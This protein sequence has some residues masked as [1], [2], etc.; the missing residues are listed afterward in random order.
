MV[1]KQF[2][3]EVGLH[4]G[5]P[6]VPFVFI[7]PVDVFSEEQQT[8]DLIELLFADDFVLVSKIEEDLLNKTLMWQKCYEKHSMT[9]KLRRQ[10]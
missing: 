9:M 5:S 1:I 7:L 10:K 8:D 2:N 4:Q 3:I 6:L